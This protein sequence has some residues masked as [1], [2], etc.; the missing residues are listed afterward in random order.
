MLA[1]DGRTL[2]PSAVAEAAAGAPVGCP[3]DARA[4][5]AAARRVV[6]AHVAQGRPFY[7]VTTGVGVLR[8]R[9]VGDR[10]EHQRALL[11]SHAA[12]TGAPMAPRLVRA[13]MVV[14]LNQLLAGGA[15][16]SDALLDALAGALG[17][18]IVPVA[19]ERGSLGIGD[20]VSLAEIPLALLGDGEAHARGARPR[21]PRGRRAL[22]GRR[23]PAGRRGAGAR[24]PRRAGAGPARRRGVHLLQRADD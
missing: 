13:A 5:N 6:E 18:G 12:G 21:P 9:P 1:L 11:R 7:G 14:R 23:A 16:V 2:A 22:R 15:G 4:R 3:E 19:H 20:L 24:R 10:A 8:D 17:A